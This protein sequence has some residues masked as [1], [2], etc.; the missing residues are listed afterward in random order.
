M[1]RCAPR[2]TRFFALLATVA[3]E[4][5]QEPGP[6]QSASAGRQA[7]LQRESLLNARSRLV[8]NKNSGETAQNETRHNHGGLEGLWSGKTSLAI[9][10][11]L[12]HRGN[13]S[14]RSSR[15]RTISF[16]SVHDR[17]FDRNLGASPIF[18]DR[19]NLPHEWIILDNSDGGMSNRDIS[20]IY[21]QSQSQA[22]NDLQVFVHPDVILPYGFYEDFMKKLD[23]IDHMDP[24]WGVLG[25]AG[26]PAWWV[27]ASGDHTK[28][29][30][31]IYSMDWLF[32]SGTDSAQMQTLDEHLL[33]LRRQTGLWFDRSL[34][35]FDLY[36][37]DIALS[38]RNAGKKAYL[39][40]V[41]VK[42]KTVDQNGLPY[43]NDDFVAK[44][45]RPEYAQRAERTKQYLMSKWCSSGLLPCYGTAYDLLGCP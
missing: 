33:V 15:S 13:T 38:S 20:S 10:S 5:C 14:A 24:N 4:V 19:A 12:Y 37:S 45:H 16:I 21:A 17:F 41:C 11:N 2:T 18:M 6:L 35:G 32:H 43:S 8:A 42:H 7:L 25:T 26:V 44:M 39:L 22:V 27:P 28:V 23:M 29:A 1:R 40:N 31:S 9:M 3:G 30:S 34:P 36:G